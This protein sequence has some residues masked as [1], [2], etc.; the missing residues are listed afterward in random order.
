MTKEKI[1]ERIK[2][3]ERE[4]DDLEKELMWVEDE[5]KTLYNQLDKLKD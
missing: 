1:K 5:L 4:A 2:L 3:L